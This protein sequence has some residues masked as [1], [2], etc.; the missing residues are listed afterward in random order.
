M[1][2]EQRYC[3]PHNPKPTAQAAEVKSSQKN[4]TANSHLPL[5]P[6]GNHSVMDIRF[7]G[8]PDRA[9]IDRAGIDRAGIDR[10]TDRSVSE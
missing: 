1:F 7:D 10:E 6:H 5:S 8:T 4:L 3:T 9:G 2:C